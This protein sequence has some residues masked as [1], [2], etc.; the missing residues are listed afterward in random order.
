[1]SVLPIPLS[2]RFRRMPCCRASIFQ[3][4]L[5]HA[6]DDPIWLFT[7]DGVALGI[8]VQSSEEREAGRFLL[9]LGKT[10]TRGGDAGRQIHLVRAH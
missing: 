3:P 7:H 1:M 4:R 9:A 6:A 8:G 5:F 2:L 10:G